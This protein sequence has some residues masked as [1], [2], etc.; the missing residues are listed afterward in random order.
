MS[1]SRFEAKVD[2]EAPDRTSSQSESMACWNWRAKRRN[3]TSK[4]SIAFDG[5][6]KE[7]GGELIGDQFSTSTCANALV[8]IIEP[9]Q[10]GNGTKLIFRLK[11]VQDRRRF[12]Y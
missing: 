5:D 4:S 7:D 12:I 10:R 8:P 3:C 9:H 11:I 6:V 2:M 1:R